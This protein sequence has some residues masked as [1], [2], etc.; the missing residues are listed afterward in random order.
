LG[1]TTWNKGKRH[2]TLS[3]NV[4]IGAGAKILGPI[5]L[6]N[7]RISGYYFKGISR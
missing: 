5:T 4:V 7:T 3:N 6:G 2:P 1:G